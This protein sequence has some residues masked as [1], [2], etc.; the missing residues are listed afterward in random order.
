[1]FR[2]ASTDLASQTSGLGVPKLLG[3][4][5]MMPNGDVVCTNSLLGSQAI[6]R[7]HSE[8][9]ERTTQHCANCGA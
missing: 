9:S 3:A 4:T 7:P 2:R 8:T 5:S 6:V 1:L